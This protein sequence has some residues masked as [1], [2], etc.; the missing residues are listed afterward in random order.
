MTTEERLRGL[1]SSPEPGKALRSLILELSRTG[2]TR[3]EIYGL[4]ERF[5]LEMRQREGYREADEGTVLDA[6]DALSEW[7]HPRGQLLADDQPGNGSP[8]VGP[9]DGR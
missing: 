8:E 4:L 5:L 9:P 1:F 6:M 7:C 2:Q 3:E